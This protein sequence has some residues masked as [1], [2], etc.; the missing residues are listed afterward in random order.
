MECGAIA[1]TSARTFPTVTWLGDFCSSLD[2][3][4][5][6]D[7]VLLASCNHAGRDT[8]DGLTILGI[9]EQNSEDRSD[10]ELFVMLSAASYQARCGE[11]HDRPTGGPTVFMDCSSYAAGEEEI[12]PYSVLSPGSSG[13]RDHRP[14][15]WRNSW[16]L[17]DIAH[18][19][20]GWHTSSC[21]TPE[22]AEPRERHVTYETASSDAAAAAAAAAATASS[23]LDLAAKADT[24][25]C[26][27]HPVSLIPLVSAIMSTDAVAT[28]PTTFAS[29]ARA[30][31]VAAGILKSIVFVASEA[32]DAFVDSISVTLCFGNVGSRY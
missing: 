5:A 8:L 6:A 19:S 27:R 29:A 15:R 9:T 13:P 11:L 16:N 20:Y 17:A 30:E 22:R 28:A 14:G 18:E 1:V 12:D 2:H 23:A 4:R 21:T 7:M 24:M 10:R 3:Q 32:D 25:A 31:A 26:E